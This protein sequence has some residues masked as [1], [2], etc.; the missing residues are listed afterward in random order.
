M[1]DWCSRICTLR[2]ICHHAILIVVVPSQGYF[3]SLREATDP[4]FIHWLV[5]QVALHKP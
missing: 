2:D 4:V 5:H 3:S 1:P